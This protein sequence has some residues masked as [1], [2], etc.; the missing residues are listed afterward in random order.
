MSRA[1]PLLPLCAIIYVTGRPLHLP[2]VMVELAL[3]QSVKVPGLKLDPMAGYPEIVCGFIWSFKQ[4]TVQNI[5]VGHAC[6]SI[7]FRINY[8]LIILF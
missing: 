8:F 5:K 2:S 7:L 6:F 3:V 1:V 4:I